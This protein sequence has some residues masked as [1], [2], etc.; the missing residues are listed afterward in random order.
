MN[1]RVWV[2]SSYSGGSDGN[3]VEVANH[4]SCVLVR[5][6]KN[7]IGAVLRFSP[8]AWRRFADRV[9]RSLASDFGQAY[10]GHFPV[11]ECPLLLCQ[12]G[13]HGSRRARFV[14]S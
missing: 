3:C 2:K 10:R 1:K 11:W 12:V 14:T 13:R 4:G 6:T 9:K 8:D 5:D 7:K